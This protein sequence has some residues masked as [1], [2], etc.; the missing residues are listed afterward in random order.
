MN[1]E[2]KLA[3]EIIKKSLLV[4][5]AASWDEPLA[6]FLRFESNTFPTRY[7]TLSNDPSVLWSE[8]EDR[9]KARYFHGFLFMTGWAH[10]I[11]ELGDKE[12]LRRVSDLV[13]C[14]QAKYPLDNGLLDGAA[15]HDET[16]AQRLNIILGLII[17]MGSLSSETVIERL[18]TL[19]DK[20]AQLLE[21]QE[22]H[23]GLNNHGMFQDISLRNYSI[24]ARWAPAESRERKLRT[25]LDRIRRY[26]IHSYTSEGVHVE[27]TPTY[28]LMVSRNLQQHVEVL[29]ALE[30]SDQA[31]VENLLSRAGSYATNV[32]MPNGLFPP[33]S[34]TTKIGLSS[35]VGNLFDDEFDY[36]CSAGKQGK[37]PTQKTIVY[38]KSGYGIYRSD[39]DSAGA[40]YLLFQAAYNNNY[41][42]HSDDL[43]IVL[44]ANGREVITEP[45][46]FSYNYKDPYSRYAYSQ[47]SHNN[48]V[49]NNQ[50]TLRTDENRSTVKIIESSIGEENFKITGET[51][52]LKGV[53][54][55]RT[56][57][58]YGAAR[59]ESISIIDHLQSDDIC[60][61]SQHWNI[62]P[63]LDVV[64]H[65][66]G[67]EVY[68]GNKKVL[69]A[70]IEVDTSIKV[71]TFRG[72][73]K[74]R[75]LGW[76]FPSFG[77][78]VPT[79]VV[80][81]SYS[82]QGSIVVKTVFNT[83]DFFYT[84]RGLAPANSNGWK[85]T[86]IGRGLNYIQN[87]YTTEDPQV[88]LVFV[89]SAMGLIGNFSY[90]YKATLDSIKCSSIYI[91]DDFGD[92]GSYYLQE[93]N[94]TS[95]FETVQKFILAKIE[96][97]GNRKRP[98][99]FVGSSKGG[100]A[101]LLHGL[102][103]ENSRIFVGAPQ[104]KIGSFIEKPHPNILKYMTGSNDAAAIQS[105]DAVLYEDH[106][107]GNN[108]SQVTIAVGKGDHHYKNHVLPWV[109]HAK[110]RGLI[111][112]TIVRE[113]TPHSEIGRVYRDLLKKEIENSS[114]KTANPINSLS[115]AE[116]EKEN[117][118]TDRE[119]Q[120]GEKSVWFDKV[121]GR[122]F[123]ST[124]NIENTEVAYRLYRENEL[125]L[126]VPYQ[127]I[128]YTSWVNLSS[129]RY[130]VRYFRRNLTSG[131]V[132]KET[133]GWVT[134]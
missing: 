48:I 113:G 103:I 102:K 50:S 92:Q 25:A 57:H 45:G 15:Y 115:L 73:T 28:H 61:Y 36:A 71:E 20:T 88:P 96:E 132:S 60:E 89:F 10:K 32:I 78:K 51:G 79:N 68:D 67:F 6:K 117:K 7:G 74:P 64:T 77:E 122:L 43:S 133:S 100:T 123:A 55:R 4:K 134:I 1:L 34:D 86:N 44:Y 63:G 75:V 118:R 46:P 47:F 39:W 112:N 87:D 37:K 129:G 128:N 31:D 95:I 49:V 56:V 23:S 125:C 81:V 9:T 8:E 104:T 80:K 66:N 59:K 27:N 106:Y 29:R 105:L 85:R 111:V 35:N 94:D 17:S 41:H 5:T 11:S 131:F 16:T 127:K 42:K 54:H 83:S 110:K 33:I 2:C 19:A 24:I 97:S 21:S 99:Y 14:W 93:K 76:S 70:I 52:R 18:R 90:N 58:V 120:V 130:R 30:I 40:T 107:F 13:D 82:G 12:A 22:F 72:V 38:S 126:S 69:D 26:F 65:G 116:D 109:E 121:S 108:T 53:E 98:I 101:A 124:E 91:L 3:H 62:A 114:M 119:P 84:D